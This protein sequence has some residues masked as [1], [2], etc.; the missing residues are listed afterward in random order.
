MTVKQ[1][2]SAACRLIYEVP[3]DAKSPSGAF[4]GG[5]VKA[6]GKE[7]PVKLVTEILGGPQTE[8]VKGRGT[9]RNVFTTA[10]PA[11]AGGSS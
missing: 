9:G 4:G 7:E 2:Y 6:A 10:R 11:E 8:T 3:F 5:L 1:L